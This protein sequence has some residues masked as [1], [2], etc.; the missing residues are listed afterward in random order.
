[1]SFSNPEMRMA[2]SQ[3]R[4]VAEM[5]DEPKNNVVTEKLGNNII[6]SYPSTY[7]DFMDVEKPQI[8]VIEGTRKGMKS[9]L[10]CSDWY[11]LVPAPK[12]SRPQME[13]IPQPRRYRNHPCEEVVSKIDSCRHLCTVIT[14]KCQKG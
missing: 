8:G 9:E 12:D 3:T 2:T 13:W 10:L 14:N 5:E 4:R 7:T 6:F 11:E 1:M